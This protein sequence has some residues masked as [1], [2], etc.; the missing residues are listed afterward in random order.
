MTLQVVWPKTWMAE[1]FERAGVDTI[2]HL[3]FDPV[4][5]EGPIWW[6]T[7]QAARS[8]AKGHE[9]WLTAPNWYDFVSLPRHLLSRDV[10]ATT[11]G[12][13]VETTGLTAFVKPADSKIVGP[14]NIGRA[15][16]SLASEWAE[17]CMSVCQVPGATPALVSEPVEWSEEWRVWTDGGH[18]L[19]MS[20]YQC[21]GETWDDDWQRE[22]PSLRL[23]SFAAEAVK[24]V[25]QPCTVD[26]GVFSDDTMA[27]V[28][29]NPIW[30]S[31]PYTSDFAAIYSGI[32]T[33]YEWAVVGRG[34]R[35]K[36]DAW[37]Q[38]KF[39][40]GVR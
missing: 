11:I 16:V 14:G 39:P 21:N 1:E 40:L 27:I 25:G 12:M 28:E 3:G 23:R 15:S 7:E 18:I 30:S 2:R 5:Q 31:G 37:L 29:L 22:D 35:W 24:V 8:I 4:V 13:L 32:K 34:R 10:W 20:M 17:E 38:S 36:P 9:T 6:A 19:E 26:V 33:S